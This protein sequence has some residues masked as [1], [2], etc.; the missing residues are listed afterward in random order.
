MDAIPLNKYREV[1]EMMKHTRLEERHLSNGDLITVTR[2]GNTYGF[3]HAFNPFDEA[4]EC[5]HF[6]N[7]ATAYKMFADTLRDDVLET[8]Y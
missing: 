2:Y 8:S 5:H 6:L 7:K 4:P 1:I 3:M